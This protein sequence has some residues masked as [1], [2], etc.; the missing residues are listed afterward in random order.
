M[1][2]CAALPGKRHTGRD[3]MRRF[4]IVRLLAVLAIL[5]SLPA[6]AET[7]LRLG[8]GPD[9]ES[10]D[11]H[12]AVSVA[13]NR[14]LTSLYEGLL[15]LDAAGR[16][17][18]GAAESWTTSADGLV[19][20]FRLRADGR[21]SDGS[22]VTAEDFVFAW[23]RA[24]MPATRSQFADLLYPVRNAMAVASGRLPPTELG[25]R[26]VDHRTFEVT[27]ARP[28]PNFTDYLYHRATYPLHAPSLERHGDGFVRPGNLVGNGPF[29]LVEAVPHSHVRLIRNPHYHSLDTVGADTV[30]LMVTEDGPSELNR[31][32]TGELHATASVPPNRIDWARDNLG[33]AMRVAPLAS[34]LFLAPNLR[35]EPWKSRPELRRA[36]SLALDRGALVEKVLK[37]GLPSHAFVP[38]GLDGYEPPRPA[39][40]GVPQ[41]ERDALARRILR[42][43]GYGPGNPLTVRLLY[44][45][46]DTLKQMAVAIAAMWHEKLGVR[47]E[48]EN[49]EFRVV[50]NRIRQGNY[51]DMVLRTWQWVF[52][53]KY[54]E[55]L[56][57]REERNGNGYANPVFDALM[58]R[59]ETTVSREDFMA[60]L[61][62]AEAVAL[63]DQ[64]VIPI[65]VNASRH[66]V[67]PRLEGWEDNLR[68]AHYARWL[69]LRP[70]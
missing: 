19:Y 39:M 29:M 68:D 28:K 1:A 35:N 61:H 12:R 60:R 59:A 22:P 16:L 27:L 26:A 69:R 49:Q 34:A 5:L 56:R 55:I 41:A 14:I 3:Q 37:H 57:S 18:P 54:L 48:L 64:A 11:P 63:A 45:T 43:A 58:D 21:W 52:P 4:H 70:E 6:S 7:E 30:L 8:N 25:V 32:R 36:L 47:T 46:S 20:R 38:P 42:D 51:P 24:V 53:E 66:L 44:H 67:S 9:S 10:L 65:A 13:D 50:M 17:I 23:R 15:T 40:A 31:F 2:L 62:E 33:T